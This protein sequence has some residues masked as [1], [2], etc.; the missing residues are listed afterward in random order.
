MDERQK[1]IEDSLFP[2]GAKAVKFHFHSPPDTTLMSQIPDPGKLQEMSRR[3]RQDRQKEKGRG[4]LGKLGFN[5]EMEA[6]L[7]QRKTRTFNAFSL[8]ELMEFQQ[9][10]EDV[11]AYQDPEE[12]EITWSMVDAVRT[13]CRNAIR[14]HAGMRDSNT[15]GPSGENF[16]AYVHLN[17]QFLVMW[18]EVYDNPNAELL[19]WSYAT[20]TYAK[21]WRGC[22][23][24]AP[25]VT[26]TVAT[27]QSNQQH[28]NDICLY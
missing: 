1:R 15:L 24:M 7:T 23:G 21:K 22:P 2:E 20:N 4:G 14:V 26:Q 19:F 8:S 11:A 9:A 12:D 28:A 25:K 6:I 18:R 5:N 27:G 10:V 16:K 13:V 17:L 3:K